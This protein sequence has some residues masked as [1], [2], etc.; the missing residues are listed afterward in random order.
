VKDSLIAS[1]L[2]PLDS[3][4][5]LYY[6]VLV[7]AA[8]KGAAKGYEWLTDLLDKRKKGKA[9]EIGR[10]TEDAVRTR[11][12]AEHLIA[13]QEKTIVRQDTELAAALRKGAEAVKEAEDL[14]AQVVKLDAKLTTAGRQWFEREGVIDELGR[15]L[16]KLE[17]GTK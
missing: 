2:P 10:L 17:D 7:L 15:R 8:I 1:A 5:V 9:D 12:E 6:A 13:L 11:E 3:S 14:R 4:T 16:K